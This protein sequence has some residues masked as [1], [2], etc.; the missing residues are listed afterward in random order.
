[1]KSNDCGK[2]FLC[3]LVNI[4][5]LVRGVSRTWRQVAVILKPQSNNQ[6]QKKNWS[7]SSPALIILP[8]WRSKLATATSISVLFLSLVRQL[9][10]EISGR[11]HGV[12]EITSIMKRAN[13]T[14]EWYQV[15]SISSQN[16]PTKH[17]FSE[18]TQ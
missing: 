6:N 14:V 9:L 15:H 11:L 3:F 17:F 10:L 18:K 2:I 7:P 16:S 4:I 1:M 8:G 13:Q 12:Y 5:Y